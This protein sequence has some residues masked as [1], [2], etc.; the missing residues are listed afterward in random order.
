MKSKRFVSKLQ[1][2]PKSENFFTLLADNEEIDL[3]M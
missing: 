2:S 3:R 1:V